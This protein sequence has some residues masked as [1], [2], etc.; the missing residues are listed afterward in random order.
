MG[1]TS[2]MTVGCNPWIFFVLLKHVGRS[3]R[4]FSSRT[5]R[6][7]LP[8][9]FKRM[10]DRHKC[11]FY[12]SLDQWWYQADSV[13]KHV[14]A[15]TMDSTNGDAQ[16]NCDDTNQDISQDTQI[17]CNSQ[18]EPSSTSKKNSRPSFTLLWEDGR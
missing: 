2:S 9:Q 6:T 10:I 12:D 13:M 18:L 7:N 1:S 15:T 5:K 8:I 14:S 3:L 4:L 11:K 17:E 16:D